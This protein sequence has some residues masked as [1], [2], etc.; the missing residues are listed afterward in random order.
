MKA[1]DK[2]DTVRMFLFVGKTITRGQQ[3]K[4]ISRKPMREFNRNFSNQRAVKM[5]NSFPEGEIKEHAK[6]VWIS[7]GCGNSYIG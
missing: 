1:I 4:M 3:C 2:V 5:E 6:V 7:T